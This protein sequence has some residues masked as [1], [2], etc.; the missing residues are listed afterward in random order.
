MINI[1]I[2]Y[3]GEGLAPLLQ[4]LG[5]EP[6]KAAEI[7]GQESGREAGAAPSCHSSFVGSD[8]R[9]LWTEPP[10][11]TRLQSPYPTLAPVC[12]HT[13]TETLDPGG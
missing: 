11:P 4:G 2:D 6:G 10:T 9:H 12:A 8:N 7:L 13:Q 3:L 1:V 5:R